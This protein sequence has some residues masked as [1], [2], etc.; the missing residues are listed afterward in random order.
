MYSWPNPSPRSRRLCILAVSFLILLLSV[1]AARSEPIRIAFAGPTSG[2]GAEDGLSAVRAIELVFERVND[3][4]GIGGRPLALDV[5][6]DQNDPD[7]ARKN[8]STILAQNQTV[9]V[10]GH[11]YSTCSIAAGAVYAE[12]GIAAI[13]NAATSVAVTRD[14]DWYFRVIYN[15]TVQGS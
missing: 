15:D 2:P 11:N 3:T 1:E 14:N 7:L 10:I 8:A 12:G 5:Y 4:G 13:T 9:A 6:D